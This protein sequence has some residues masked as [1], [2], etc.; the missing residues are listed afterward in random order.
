MVAAS[1]PGMPRFR[2]VWPKS[3]SVSVH[4]GYNKS[5]SGAGRVKEQGVK[6]VSQRLTME[7][8]ANG[9]DYVVSG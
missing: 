5:N 8:A 4:P 3:G 9:L 2:A 1:L 6:C 7:T